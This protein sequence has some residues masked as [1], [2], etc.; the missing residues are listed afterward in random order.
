MGSGSN[1]FHL[2]RT[3]LATM[4]TESDTEWTQP[5][6]SPQPAAPFKALDEDGRSELR[7]WLRSARETPARQEVE[8]AKAS[9][10]KSKDAEARVHVAI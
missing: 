6:M 2:V 9:A 3:D 1:E 4:I 10:E 5:S 7:Q 8:K